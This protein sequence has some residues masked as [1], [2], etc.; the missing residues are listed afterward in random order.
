[1]ATGSPS[2][3]RVRAAL[4]ALL[5][6]LLSVPT[7]RSSDLGADDGDLGGL[8]HCCTPVWPVWALPVVVSVV[9]M[10]GR[11]MYTAMGRHLYTPVWRSEEHTSELQSRE[12]LVCRLLREKLTYWRL[13]TGN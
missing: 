3:S 1:R 9:I 10:T 12:K 8:C 4:R 6:S 13:N 11:H 5:R 2:A 7:R